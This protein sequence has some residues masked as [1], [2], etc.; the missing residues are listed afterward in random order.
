MNMDETEY[1]ISQCS[2]KSNSMFQSEEKSDVKDFNGSKKLRHANSLS[3]LQRESIQQQDKSAV[4]SK[5][6]NLLSEAKS[7]KSSNGDYNN[8]FK[9]LEEQNK[10]FL[11]KLEEIEGKIKE[12]DHQL[13]IEK[14]KNEVLESN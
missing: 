13:I 3:K 4:K 5:L 11:K 9:A 1:E 7:S 6:A 12:K 2:L 14:T 8:K 10:M